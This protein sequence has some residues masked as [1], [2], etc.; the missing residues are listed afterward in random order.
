[1]TGSMLATIHNERFFVRFLD[2][3]RA[4]IDGGWYFE[5]RD[6]MLHRFY[7]TGSKG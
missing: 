1:M 7:R 5:F 4:S 2:E 3:I 6:W